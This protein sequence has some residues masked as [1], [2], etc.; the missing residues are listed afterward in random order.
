MYLYGCAHNP[1]LAAHSPNTTEFQ[2]V[3]LQPL[4][5]KGSLSSDVLSKARQ[6]DQTFVENHGSRVQQVS[7]LTFAALKRRCLS[8]LIKAE[9]DPSLYSGTITVF[10]GNWLTYHSYWSSI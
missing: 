2:A 1:P 8:F 10:G 7:C 5:Y 4:C 9:L 6:P 3:D